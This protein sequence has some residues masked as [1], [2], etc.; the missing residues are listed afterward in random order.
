MTST[1]LSPEIW[2]TA[3]YDALC[4]GGPTALAAEAMARRLTTTKGSFYWHFKDVPAYHAALVH[5]WQAAALADVLA[6]LEETGAPD[7]RL[8]NFGKSILASKTETA[9]RAWAN[10]DPSVAKS[11]AYVD[12]KRLAYIQHLLDTFGLRNPAFSQAI[13]AALIGLP[14]IKIHPADSHAGFE[15]LVDTILALT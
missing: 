9:L 1:R 15:A 4:D 12:E 2:I 5:H 10:S 8:R 11:M 7:K 3:G 13:L 14:Q 6:C